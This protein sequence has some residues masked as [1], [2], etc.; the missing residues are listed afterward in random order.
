MFTVDADDFYEGC[1]ELDLLL[2]IRDRNPN[3]RITLFTIPGRCTPEFIRDFQR[4]HPWA[5][6]AAHGWM[7]ES[8]R[9]CERWTYEEAR[10]YL[11]R[12]EPLGL[13]RGFKAPG[14]QIS[15]GTFRA[16]LE[17]GYWVADQAYNDMRRPIGLRTYLVGGASIHCHMGNLNGRNEN[18][19]Q[20]MQDALLTAQ[21]VTISEK[22]RMSKSKLPPAKAGGF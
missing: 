4:E 11:R 6:L 9:E 1:E 7:H 19:I 21:C 5:E 8:N 16:L 20:A 13:V 17:A 22:L 12:I 10:T 15:S 18:T 3:L 2:S 14:W